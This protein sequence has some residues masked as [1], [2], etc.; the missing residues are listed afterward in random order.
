MVN[1]IFA[2]EKKKP[3]KPQA[4]PTKIILLSD[5]TKTDSSRSAKKRTGEKPDERLQLPDVL[6][7]G[8]DTAK[9]VA[10]KKITIS[11]DQ[12]EL[13]NPP[14]LYDPLQGEDIE[15][16][17][18]VV[19][20]QPDA[21]NKFR[22]AELTAYGGV[23]EQY[24]GSGK[25]WQ[26]LSEFDYGIEASVVHLG[27][28][29]ENSQKDDIALGFR[30]GLSPATSNQW[31]LHAQYASSDFGLHGSAVPEHTRELVSTTGQLT[32]QFDFGAGVK[33]TVEADFEKG[34]L[35]DAADST[36]ADL[37]DVDNTYFAVSGE[38]A[39]L[40]ANSELKLKAKTLSDRVKTAQND[41]AKIVWYAANLSYNFAISSKISTELS[42]D[43]TAIK[44][45]KGQTE[46]KLRPGVRLFFA[47]SRKL[48]A[49]ASYSS[50]FEYLPWKNALST[51]IYFANQAR[52][53]PE[54]IRWKIGVNVDWQVT[55]GFVF[56]A[57]YESKHID[58]FNYFTRNPLGT[59]DLN[60]GDFKLGLASVGGRLNLSDYVKMEFSLNVFEDAFLFG[61]GNFN[62]IFDIPYR[63]EFRAPLKIEWTPVEKLLFEVNTAWIGARRTTLLPVELP[64]S[65]ASGFQELPSYIYA[66]FH[67]NYQLNAH[68][69][70]YAKINNIFDDT[71]DTWQGYREMG[72]NGLVGV[73]YNR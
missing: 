66:S 34:D 27:G 56:K 30:L 45:D 15:K 52:P 2:Q 39:K 61:D 16:G 14:S 71:F 64:N 58:G 70:A 67:S 43:L 73:R 6:I 24:G 72:I 19:M 35:R 42:A 51:N 38:I 18:R 22:Q 46:T 25:W 47:P 44:I 49:T 29:F 57:K 13:V 63:G 23:Y 33:S 1:A 31:R 62:S 65:Q 10:G 40:F 50:G 7:Y 17:A 20:L 53:L 11:P 26:A 69:E 41:S 68:F 12:P 9:R 60:R 59:F 32:G 48:I 55:K 3:K 28:Q 5:T 4:P 21:Q 37:F 8:S 54:E 36:V